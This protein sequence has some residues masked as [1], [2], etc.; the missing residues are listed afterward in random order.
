MRSRSSREGG[1]T[2][3]RAVFYIVAAF[4]AI[5]VLT[6]LI[7]KPLDFKAKC[8][9]SRDIACGC[10][11]D[12]ADIKRR[13]LLIVDTTDPLRAGKFADI[14][15]L[16]TEFASGSKSFYDWLM[17]GK[18]PDQTSVYLL[19]TVAPP[20]MRPIAVFCT[21]PPSISVAIGHTAKKIRELQSAYSSAVSSTL[22][23]LEQGRT[24]DQSPIIEALAILTGNASAWRP[25]GTII[26]ASD[27]LQNTP[28]CGYFEKILKIPS[29][30]QLP[31]SCMQEIRTLRER[32][33][34]TPTYPEPAVVALCEA[35]GKPRKDGLLSF[36]RDVF[37]EPL[38]YDVLLTCH[39]REISNRR[40][41]LSSSLK[42]R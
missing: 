21:Q 1:D 37:Q 13:N 28:Q 40:T 16:L 14:E 26:L 11:A 32:L 41:M 36:W 12:P 23:T 19:S 20:D 9:P 35:P 22:R 31:S 15:E 2:T 33:R 34:P 27:L 42:A 8:D 29:L 5:A 3:A 6:Y 18:Q 7:A 17:D 30:A 25:G 38:G 10:P 24:A 39:P 4:A